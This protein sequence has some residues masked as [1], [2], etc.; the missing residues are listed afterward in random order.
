MPP[1]LFTPK[2]IEDVAPVPTVPGKSVRRTP[3]AV[4]PGAGVLKYAPGIWRIG[5]TGS[6]AGS[7]FLFQLQLAGSVSA[8]LK[9]HAPIRSSRSL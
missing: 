4:A 7:G 3:P 8:G 5:V 9:F 1:V 2:A 6:M